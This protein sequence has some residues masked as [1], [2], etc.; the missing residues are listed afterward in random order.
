MGSRVPVCALACLLVAL[1]INAVAGETVTVGVNVVNP[2]RLSA[3]DRQ[4]L[5]DQLQTA[6]VRVIRAPLSPAWDGDD[7]GPAT[8]FI[9]RASERGIKADLI[10][11]LQYREGAQRRPAVKDLPAMWPSFPL[12]VA[13][14]ERFRAVFKPLFERLETTGITF[15][16]LELGNEINWTAFN[17]DFPIP[18]EGRVFGEADLTRD[19]EAI[20]IA[21]G[22]RAYLRTLGVLKDI[23]DHSRLNRGTP[24]LSAGLSDPGPAGSRPGSKT[25]AVTIGATLQYLRANGLDA[26]V[27]AYGVHTYPVAKASAQRL[28]QLEEDTL[29]ECRPPGHVAI[30]RQIFS[31]EADSEIFDART[32]FRENVSKGDRVRSSM[33]ADVRALIEYV[34]RDDV[35]LH[36]TLEKTCSG[37]SDSSVTSNQGSRSSPSPVL[38]G[39]EPHQLVAARSSWG[40]NCSNSDLAAQRHRRHSLTERRSQ[41]LVPR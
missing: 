17:G 40:K 32:H 14:P 7:Y 13:D 15:A 29:A 41:A 38:A 4:A 1:G 6:G 36:A 31:A 30:L 33:P 16:A 10:V 20:R 27:D 39:S 23:R 21:E 24:I 34:Y 11:G 5:L 18:G 8:D 37:A 28:K 2:Q 12:S 35:E 3:G 25:D 19:P 9:R 26:L 22:Y